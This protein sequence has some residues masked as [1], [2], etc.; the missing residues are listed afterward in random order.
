[1][2]KDVNEKGIGKASFKCI[3]DCLTLLCGYSKGYVLLN[4]L[5]IMIEG[6][7]PA[8]LIV[9]MQRIINMLQ[10]GQ[11]KLSDIVSCIGIYVVVKVV[12][13]LEMALHSYY[14]NQFNLKFAQYINLKM[15]DKAVQLNLK[16]YED[17]ETYNIINRA[18]TQKGASILSYISELL[19]IIR[20]FIIIGST[21]AILIRFK[22]WIVLVS[23]AVPAMR[24][25]VMISIDR[26][27]YKLR[28]S[29]TQRERQNWYINYI[30]LTGRAFKEIKI[31]GLSKY[32][33]R[34]YKKRSDGFIEEDLKMQQKTTILTIVSDIIDCLFTGA[35]F[36]Y[37]VLLGV[38]G[39]ILIGDVAA[40]IECIENI[41]NSAQEIFSEVG[42]I[43]EQSLYVGLLFEFFNISEK[44]QEIEK[45][46]KHIEKIELKHVSFRYGEEYVLKNISLTLC[47]GQTVALVGQNGSGKTTL[48]KLILGFYDN[49]EGEIYINGTELRDV[50]LE[51]YRKRISCIFQ[52]YQKYETT[53]RENVAFGD[54]SKIDCDD[55]IWKA[56][57]DAKVQDRIRDI[58]VLDAVI[59][60]WFGERELSAGEWQRIAIARALVKKA[61]MYVF[62][63]PDA[64]LDIMN[65]KEL[66]S[67]YKN[68]MAGNIGIFITHKVHYVSLVAE[69]IYV[70]QQGEITER[71]KH[72][73][74]LSNKGIYYMLFRNCNN[75]DERS[76]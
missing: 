35:L 36:T 70:L 37:T 66:I 2:G 63:E 27:W 28:V 14:N 65:Q 45:A 41:K 57:R 48:I 55:A 16:D 25:A 18:Q 15:L 60:N 58:G 22:W 61:D 53:V 44:K 62:D 24:C 52:D 20:Q 7:V 46:I 74:L 31:L 43:A 26:Q 13:T 32:L 47:A 68:I 40:Y 10:F 64:S 75:T 23:L 8:V 19:E 51:S 42:S 50:G 29:R 17:S 30:L 54:L 12:I 6:L 71:G 67:I 3:K 21:T 11:Y 9:I 49:Y 69:M 56:L 59:G 34:K 76:I 72:E 39:K 5:M 73:E 33:I 1:M 38:A 4:F